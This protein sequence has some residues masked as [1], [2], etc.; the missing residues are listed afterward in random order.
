MPGLKIVFM[1]RQNVG[2]SLSYQFVLCKS[3]EVKEEQD[4]N[5]KE[6]PQ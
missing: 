1:S 5:S 4:E 3:R 2:R 6:H